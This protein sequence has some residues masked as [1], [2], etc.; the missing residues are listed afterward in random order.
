MVEGTEGT[1]ARYACCKADFQSLGIKNRD[2]TDPLGRLH[3]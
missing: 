1:F 2:G 3:V